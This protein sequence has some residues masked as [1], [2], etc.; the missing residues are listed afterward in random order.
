MAKQPQ[1]L[2]GFGPDAEFQGLESEERAVMEGQEDEIFDEGIQKASL[3]ARK[4]NP[5]GPQFPALDSYF[6]AK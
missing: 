1:K 4:S 5:Y 3:N 2:G 6:K